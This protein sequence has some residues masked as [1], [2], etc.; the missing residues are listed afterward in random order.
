[1]STI[2]YF[3]PMPVIT[4]VHITRK[5]EKA[6]K[7]CEQSPKSKECHAAWEDVWELTREYRNQ[8]GQKETIDK[9]TRL[10]K[11]I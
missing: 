2:R 3:L 11:D 10:M 5:I 4:D 1:M 7:I 6:K 8:Q 9:I